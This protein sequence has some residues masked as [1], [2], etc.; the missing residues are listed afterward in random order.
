[1]EM[2]LEEEIQ[3]LSFIEICLMHDCQM[4]TLISHYS[5][6]E[7]SEDGC[8]SSTWTSRSCIVLAGG[9]GAGGHRIPNVILICRVDLE[10]NSLSEQPVGRV[11]VT[12]LPYRMAAH[13]REGGLICALS[14][15]C[16]YVI[17]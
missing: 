15:S 3:S 6:R 4:P 5:D 9:G 12:G 8:E 14:E 7:N 1:M 11:V 10:T 16:K 2:S 13:P 17:L